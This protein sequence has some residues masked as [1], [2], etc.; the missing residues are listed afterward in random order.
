MASATEDLK[1]E[2]QFSPDPESSKIPHGVR[3]DASPD[4]KCPICLDRFDN[5]SY[6]DRC[7]HKFCFR[8]IQEW[9]RNKA[10]CPLC[11]QPFNSIFHSVRT[12]N[13]FQ[14]YVLK[15]TENGSFASPGGQRFRYRT[16][17]TRERRSTRQPRRS[18]VLPE[19]PDNGVVFEGFGRQPRMYQGQ[20]LRRM[21]QRMSARRRAQSEGRSTRQV[22]EQ[23]MI[24]F[25]RELYRSGLRVRNVQDG[26]RYRDISAEF[27]RR[28]AACLHRLMPWLKR[29]LCVLFGSHGSVVNIVQHIIMSNIVRYDMESEAFQ[30]EL[31]PF[32]LSRTDHFLHEFISFAR[33]PFN[34]ESYDQRA[35]YD[36]PAPSYEE[37]SDSDLS[38]ITISPDTAQAQEEDRPTPNPS[39]L[40]L[41]LS[42]ATWDDETPG[43][44]YSVTE[45]V[46][47]ANS[48]PGETSV[49][50]EETPPQPGS[51]LLAASIKTD[52]GTNEEGSVRSIDDCLIVGYVKPLAERTPELI[53]L[54]SD[55]DASIQATS[56]EVAEQ[57]VHIRFHSTSSLSSST[58]SSSTRSS[59]SR[60]RLKRKKLKHKKSN[61][62]KRDKHHS[63]KKS[64]R[65]RS[66]A[67][68]LSRHRER[69]LS[70]VQGSSKD[71]SRIRSLSRDKHDL[72][73]PEQSSTRDRTMVTYSYSRS[74]HRAKDWNRRERARSGSREPRAHQSQDRRRSRNRERV[75]FTRSRTR[76]QNSDCAVYRHRARSRSWSRGYPAPRDRQR[77][78]SRERTYSYM[79]EY[80]E[81]NRAFSYQWERYSYHS[82]RNDGYESATRA[83]THHRKGSPCSDY[84]IR[85][86]SEST[87]FRS[88]S[89]HRDDIYYQ[90]GSYR[91]RSPSS[92]RSRTTS[93]RTDKIRQE[94]PGGKRKYKTHYLESFSSKEMKNASLQ[95]ANLSSEIHMLPRQG[96]SSPGPLSQCSSNS[97]SSSVLLESTRGSEPKFKKHKEKKRST[98]VEI[99]YEGKVTDASRHHK[100]KKKRNKKKQKR[101]KSSEQTDTEHHSPLVITIESDS[102]V[103]VSSMEDG[104]S[105]Y[106][107][108]TNLLTGNSF[109][110]DEKHVLRTMESPDT[111]PN[112]FLNRTNTDSLD[113]CRVSP[114]SDHSPPN[115]HQQTNLDQEDVNPVTDTDSHQNFKG[116]ERDYDQHCSSPS[117]TLP[118][119]SSDR[120]PLILKIPKRFI[121]GTNLFNRPTEN[122]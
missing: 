61:K 39:E 23:E 22:Q 104:N 79:R 24:R 41:G 120:P 121:N 93:G 81:R 117:R 18:P 31:R 16:T 85:S 78:R 89:S 58:R 103:I 88:P 48:S 82:R 15:A 91:S 37:E 74:E 115:P 1:M 97:K 56:T 71:R 107:T 32:L 27:F 4:A 68:R 116:E 70:R 44:S 80:Q 46:E 90:Y 21:M 17:L 92:T 118:K 3:A 59:V 55:S 12:E 76:S 95:V 72:R 38:V 34:M 52:P 111:P 101:E 25:R 28:N 35:N 51:S 105:T 20:S 73:R 112:I 122:A 57:P 106:V 50:S 60:E 9:S 14:E 100:R 102:D 84:R 30:E 26:G 94:K 109:E 13:D 45:T 64:S 108:T 98:S 96:G 42:Q 10:E 99:V 63:H 2:N 7:F 6:I 62:S 19:L 54:S 49:V 53:E 43:P 87:S 110:L 66:S 47:S 113:V 65:S 75:S 33:A 114:D 69:T 36:C 86:S 67:S 77:S 40:A 8:C 5:M 11:K 119:N 29:E 83:R